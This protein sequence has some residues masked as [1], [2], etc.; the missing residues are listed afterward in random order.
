MAEIN[1][2]PIGVTTLVE[3]MLAMT[4][5]LT[6]L[7]N[8]EA[9]KL[10]KFGRKASWK[11]DERV[12]FEGEEADEMFIL[13]G[14][15]LIVW[16]EALGIDK[17]IATLKPGENFGEMAILAGGKRGANVSAVVDSFGVSVNTAMLKNHPIIG[18]TIYKNIARVALE[19]QNMVNKQTA[20]A[21]GG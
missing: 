8:V 10:L 18:L 7:D 3:K 17:P 2:P 13:L 16:L 9:H 20:S 4:P 14:G 15:K 21:E 12:F 1:P 5:V 6:G 19:R 11:V